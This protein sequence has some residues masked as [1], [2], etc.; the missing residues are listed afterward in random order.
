MRDKDSPMPKW[1]RDLLRLRGL[2]QT[3]SLSAEKE[4]SE[5]FDPYYYR[6]TYRDVS[7]TD[8]ELLHHFLNVGW[9]K[10]YNP[11]ADFSTSHY[12]LSNPD[13]ADREMNPLV[14][15]IRYGK[16]EGRTTA[17]TSRQVSTVKE[18]SF[19]DKL[20]AVFDRHFY[21]SSFP[22]GE[23]PINP[24]DHYLNHG[25]KEGR[26]P[27]R[28]FS[29][30]HYL[31]MHH[32]VA[33]AGINPFFHYVFTGSKEGRA[34]EPL[35]KGTKEL[36]EAHKAAVNSGSAFEE[37]DHS[38]GTFRLKCAKV[39]AFYLPQFH[40]ISV[41]DTN[42]GKGFTE[43]TNLARAMPRFAGHIQPRIPRDLGF[44]DLSDGEVLRRQSDLAR[45]SGI[46]GFCFYYYWFDGTRVLEKPL[47]LLLA[48]TSINM[49]FC[50]IWANENWTRTWDGAESDIILQQSYNEE[51]DASLVRDWARHMNDARYIKLNGRPLL[52]I[53][54]PGQI[55][56]TKDTIA[57]WRMLFRSDHDL[58]PIIMMV[59]GFGDTDPTL[60]G[61]DGAL[62][63]PP[64]KLC[65]DLTPINDK[66]NWFDNNCESLVLD[67]DD[68]V[69]NSLSEDPPAYPLVK[70]AIPSWDNEARRP[71][72]GMIIH[73]G[74]PE[75]FENWMNQLVRYSKEN[76]VFGEQIICINAW[77]EWAEGAV[78]EPDVHFGGAFLNSTAR[79]VFNAPRPASE[80]IT[81]VLIVGHDANR[82]GAQ[83]L[84]LNL[85][86]TLKEHFGVS[87]AFLL[88]QDG[89]LLS[90]YLEIGEAF[91]LDGRPAEAKR[92]I[93]SIWRS[94]CRYAIV[95]TSAAGSVV[96]NLKEEGY[97]VTSLIHEL[98]GVIRSHDL[99]NAAKEIA[100][101]AD[102][103]IFPAKYV[104]E[105]FE[106][107]VGSIHGMSEIFPQGMY[108]QPISLTTEEAEGLRAELGIPTNAKIVLGA[109][110]GDL[111]KGID[112]FVS[113]GLS[114]CRE[115]SDIFFVWCGEM[116]A[117]T[118][119]WIGH[120]I[121]ESDMEE[122]VIVTGYRSDVARFFAIAD[123]FYLSSREDPFPSVILEALANGLPVV[124][125]RGCGGCDSLIEQHGCLVDTLDSH[126][127]RRAILD[128]LDTEQEE[129]N[130]KRKNAIEQYYCFEN[131]SYGLLMRL[132]QSL[133]SVSAVIPNYNYEPYLESR[134]E[135]VF[136]QTYPLRE[137]LFLDDNSS[138]NS[139]EISETYATESNRHIKT[140][141]NDINSGSPFIQWRKGVDYAVSEYV[142]IAEADDLASPDF[143][144]NIITQMNQEN[145][146]LGFCDSRQIDQNSA[147]LSDSYQAYLNEIEMGVFS[148]SF[149][150]SGID[151]LRKFLSVKNVILNVSGVVFR[152]DAL[153]E[154][155]S[156]VGDEIHHFEIA[157]DW[158]V[159]A[160]ICS[161]GG[162]V[163]YNHHALNVHRRHAASATHRLNVVSHLNEI[164]TMHRLIREKIELD[165]QTIE[166]QDTYLHYC[167]QLLNSGDA[168]TNSG[169]INS[170]SI[171][172]GAHRTR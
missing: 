81:K 110:Y 97:S 124:G 96:R 25:W 93:R 15:Y 95:N 153:R 65:Q 27:T 60:F 164:R 73:G 106:E 157:G 89:P 92:F 133:K 149:S 107:V 63:F 32:D 143:I 4:I 11:S 111:R 90:Q 53:Y 50:L 98:P 80:L 66:L 137:I 46:D 58:D 52:V 54:R 61:M 48:D 160:E 150:I 148:R 152:R 3:K 62:E 17:Q 155:L 85:G 72:Q 57:R 77:N 91:V 88:L 67:Y 142:W 145:A 35:G 22:K 6:A 31:A 37:I 14:H 12:L 83:L 82:N 122:R 151:F 55:P 68:I 38:I 115:H 163:V 158:R 166:Q 116:S 30:R 165:Q 75:K 102:R 123:L 69:T 170:R 156:R 45:S 125:H 140:H 109:G 132:S 146:I 128:T 159:Y 9:R 33:E 84:A 44:Y 5:F 120:E 113:T 169:D 167:E 29:T 130:V 139:I 13:V 34:L 99:I 131:Y 172:T 19:A 26:D 108:S 118:R 24:V 2:L 86:R 56:A 154:A 171:N 41:N 138:D 104:Q 114:I 79:A 28:W 126:E 117:E 36:Y 71:G 23:Q 136:Q 147:L 1:L 59:Q 74:S 70:T 168:G 42:W 18:S 39:L 47:E 49:P 8:S 7:G 43:W 162:G 121:F 76:P 112:R 144:E 134:L 94:G 51:N 10:G 100:L 127:I 135:S 21:L 78:L 16:A 141:L 40:S 119:T 101:H 20:E 64:H 161:S 129:F 87:V 105:K 103:V